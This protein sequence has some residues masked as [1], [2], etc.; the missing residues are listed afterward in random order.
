MTPVNTFRIIFNQYFDAGLP[1]LPNCSFI[2][3]NTSP[4]RFIDIT[5]AVASTPDAGCQDL[6]RQHQ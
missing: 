3:N 4:Y 1:Y 5:A 6:A 2:S